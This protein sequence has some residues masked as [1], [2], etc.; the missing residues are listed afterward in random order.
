MSRMQML[1]K[2]ANNSRNGEYTEKEDW[3][4]S[5]PYYDSD[6][7]N[8]KRRI[9]YAIPMYDK[10]RYGHLKATLYLEM[11]LEY[12]LTQ[13]KL[14]MFGAGF[15]SF[16]VVAAQIYMF[17]APGLYAKEKKALLPFILAG[18]GEMEGCYC[19]PGYAN[20]VENIINVGGVDHLVVQDVFRTGY[21]DYWALKLA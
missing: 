5:N 6:S 20:A 16:P 14:A 1:Q 7:G 9:C 10:R 11:N 17:V 2:T 21:S 15:I 18:L 12:F 8:D 3:V 13:L 4:Y 19:V